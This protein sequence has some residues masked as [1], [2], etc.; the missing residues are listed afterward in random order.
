MNP[1]YL[2]TIIYKNNTTLFFIS[3]QI[4]SSIPSRLITER[5]RDRETERQRD[6]ETERQRDRET[7]RNNMIIAK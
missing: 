4:D 7:E 5:Q 2:V 6:R 3:K 1:V